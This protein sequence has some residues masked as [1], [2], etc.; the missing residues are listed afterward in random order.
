MLEGKLCVWNGSDEK[1]NDYTEIFNVQ[2]DETGFTLAAPEKFGIYDILQWKYP[3][4]TVDSGSLEAKD[5]FLLTV[6]SGESNVA[7]WFGT[8]AAT[9]GITLDPSEIIF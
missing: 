3:G 9:I 7:F 2:K 6:S 5:Y 4:Q 8:S 1:A